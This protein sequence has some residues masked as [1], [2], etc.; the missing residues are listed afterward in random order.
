[1]AYCMIISTFGSEEEAVKVSKILLEEKAAA[2]CQLT[3]GVKSLYMWKGKIESSQEVILFVKTKMYLADRVEEL[4]LKNHS[5]QTPEIIQ[6]NIDD[7]NIEYL[8]WIDC[9]TDKIRSRC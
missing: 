4:I 7:G 1:M 8:N 5:Y 3:G 2:C 9:C 6:V